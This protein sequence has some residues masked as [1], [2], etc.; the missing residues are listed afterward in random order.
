[1]SE[2]AVVGYPHEVKGEGV[3][4]YVILKNKA[5]LQTYGKSLEAELR[6][7]CKTHIAAFAVPDFILFCDALPKTRS[8]KIMR[9]ILRKIAAGGSV[10]DLGDV[11]TLAEPHVVAVLVK[12]R[13]DLQSSK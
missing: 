11:S 12:A 8:G 1:V 7:L 9:R 6:A 3:F 13:Q 4:A 5:D 2:T 10:A